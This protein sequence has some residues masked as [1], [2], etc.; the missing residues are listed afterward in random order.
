MRFMLREP[1]DHDLCT[2]FQQK[3]TPAGPRV[4]S[5]GAAAAHGDDLDS[6]TDQSDPE[7]E[8]EEEEEPAPATATAE[9]VFLPAEYTHINVDA[10]GDEHGQQKAKLLNFP[11]ADYASPLRLFQH[12]F[13]DNYLREVVLPEMNRRSPGLELQ[14]GEFLR[15]LGCWFVIACNPGVARSD[16][17]STQPQTIYHS[18]PRL[19]SVI[20]RNRFNQILAAVVL[21]DRPRPPYKDR[22]HAVRQFISEWNQN[23]AD[24]FLP[25][26]ITCLDESMVEW[27]TKYTCPGWMYVKRKPHPA[28][29][30]YHTIACGK[31][32][33]IFKVELVEGKDHPPQIKV[34]HEQLGK[35]PGLLVRMTD[36]IQATNRVVVL[37]SGFCTL[38]GLIELRARGVYASV[39]IKR[40][41]Y[42]PRHVPGDELEQ[43]ASSLNIGE[44]VCRK[45]TMAIPGGVAPHPFYLV[46]MRDSKHILKL[47][48]TYGTSILE[49]EAKKRRNP[50]TG[51]I[52]S[53]QYPNVIANY[54]MARHAVDDNN[55]LRQGSISLEA[56]VGTTNWAL[57]QFFALMAMS[58]VN[59]LLLYNVMQEKK[60]KDRVSLLD[61]RRVLAEALVSNDHYKAELAALQVSHGV[62]TTRGE[63]R[64]AAEVALGGHALEKIAPYYGQY[65]GNGLRQHVKTAHLQLKCRGLGC[66][67]RVRTYCV[68]NP[69]LT[70]CAQCFALHVSE[71]SS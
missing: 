25:S 2:I 19:N 42:W 65:L 69:L 32:K 13:P 54:Y 21:T 39:V 66:A 53:F 17:W 56:T 29:N 6:A 4:A 40:K 45:G 10:R 63:K 15:W 36:T 50:S 7:S 48:A 44:H 35:T 16:F 64:R 34:A 52:V 41:R 43:R 49:G 27:L 68:C 47:M 1:F 8:E 23:M 60:R 30:E 9:C 20:S 71:N 33:V 14:Y 61:F 31:T 28:G 26:W 38:R 46:A 5:G 22:F 67:A 37:D 18:Y 70:L 59:A 57:R 58:E 62:P 11:E 12:L 24:N 51:A 3:F 55:N